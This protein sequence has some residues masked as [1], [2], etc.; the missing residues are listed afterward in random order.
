MV[1]IVVNIAESIGKYLAKI[2]L[3]FIKHLAKLTTEFHGTI[4]ELLTVLSG[5]EQDLGHE[6]IVKTYLFYQDQ[7]ANVE[8]S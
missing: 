4:N 3:F 8:K 7:S 2:H 1:K 5:N 6:N